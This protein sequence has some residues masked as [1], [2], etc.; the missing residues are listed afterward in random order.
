MSKASRRRSSARPAPPP[1]VRRSWRAVLIVGLAAIAIAAAAAV[2]WLY[3]R[4]SAPFGGPI[5]LISIDTLRADHLPIYGYR[6]GDTPNIDALARDGIVFDHA[7][8]QAP[9]TLP[10]HTSI[11]TGELPYQDGVRDNIGFVLKP[12]SDTLA[13]MLDARSFATGGVVS[14]YVL[15]KSTGIGQGFQYFN[16]DMPASSPDMSVGDVRR[17]GADSEAV[18]ARWVDAQRSSRFFLFLHLYDVH[19]P[20]QPRARFAGLAPY[21]QEVAYDDEMVGRLVQTL[22]Q[23]G[24]YKQALIILVSDHGEGLGDH[25]ELEHGIF[26]YNDTIRVAFV[27]KMPGDVQAGRHVAEPVQHID[28]VPTI[29]DLLHAPRPAGLLGRSL[30]PLLEGTGRVPEQGIYSEAMYPRYHFGWSQLYSLTD[31]RYKYIQAPHPELYDLKRDPGELHN[32]VTD[33]PNVAQAMAGALDRMIAGSKVNTPKPISADALQRLQSL[34][35]IGDVSSVSADTPASSLPDPKDML[36]VL[37]AYRHAVDLADHRQFARSIALLQKVVAGQPEMADVW[38]QLANIELRVGQAK[39]AADAYKHFIELKPDQTAGY[40][41]MATALLQMKQYDAARQN[42]ELAVKVAPK[43]EPRQAAE[44]H[45]LLAKIALAQGDAASAAREAA[46]AEGLDP[47]LPMKAFI[48]ARLLYDQGKYAAALPLFEQALAQ[49]ARRSMQV[50]GLHFYAGDT[51][52]RLDQNAAA[53]RQFQ[54]ELRYFPQDARAY[55]SLAMLYRA[56]GRNAASDQTI[57]A[58]LRASPVPA[59][60]N[61]AARLWTIFGEKQQA[62]AVLAA[63][64]RQFGAGRSGA[65]P[66]RF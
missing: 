38:D 58:L 37:D 3:A 64:R 63:A 31:S 46:L 19:Q 56:T 28:I 66:P 32:I 40:I 55:A 59:S 9:Q 33:R 47:T 16:A 6:H 25:G 1:P 24:L 44:A 60:Y 17:D 54:E 57:E 53:E 14:G 34:G 39:A 15:R 26:L 13:R 36:P 4:A 49:V 12:G 52:A 48:G 22:K 51:M 23:K 21:D 27:V 5:V 30:V 8:S 35:Y 50:P 18:A 43:D 20:Y 7:Y 61:L 2:G 29:L 11:L 65:P 10:E 62:A 42:A 41:G 45:G